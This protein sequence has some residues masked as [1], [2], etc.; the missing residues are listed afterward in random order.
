MSDYITAQQIIRLICKQVLDAFRSFGADTVCPNPALGGT[1]PT[2]FSHLPGRNHFLTYLG[3]H[4]TW[5]ELWRSGFTHPY[6]YIF[7]LH[8]RK[9]WIY[10]RYHITNAQDKQVQ[11]CKIQPERKMHFLCHLSILLLLHT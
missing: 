8:P 4:L 11:I 5:L 7:I 6:T 9:S 3:G 2:G 10:W 1:N